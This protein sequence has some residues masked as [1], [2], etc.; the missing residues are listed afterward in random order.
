MMIPMS[1]DIGCTVNP[2][3]ATSTPLQFDASHE[4]LTVPSGLYQLM[5]I[6][7]LVSCGT[8]I[9]ILLRI[10]SGVAL[11]HT[12]AILAPQRVASSAAFQTNSMRPQSQIANINV[13]K[14]TATIAN[15]IMAAPA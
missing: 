4:L 2:V 1:G 6:L 14:I 11:S 13:K 15:S 5:L 9:F 10:W 7:A 12:T 3:I 8:M